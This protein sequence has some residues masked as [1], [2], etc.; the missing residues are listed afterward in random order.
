LQE[1]PPHKFVWDAD[2]VD[3]LVAT[4]NHTS[5]Y[6][7]AAAAAA[8]SGIGL[9]PRGVTSLLKASA[10]PAM[11]RIIQAAQPPLDLKKEPGL[12]QR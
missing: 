12:F 10:V 5:P 1:E 11:V 3:T 2:M 9:T 6:C 8:L 7:V 4:L